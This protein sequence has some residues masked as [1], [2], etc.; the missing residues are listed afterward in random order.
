MKHRA[1]CGCQIQVVQGKRPRPSHRMKKTCKAHR[2]YGFKATKGRL[3]A[4]AEACEQFE[5]RSDE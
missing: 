2:G 3:V 4:V 5:Q 1:K